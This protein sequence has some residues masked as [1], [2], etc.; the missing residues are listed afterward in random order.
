[1][2]ETEYKSIYG[3]LTTIPCVYEKALTNKKACC[4]LAEHFC[5]ADREGY[6]CQSMESSSLC[7]KFLEK[8]REK[9]VFSLKTQEVDGPLPHNMEIR[10]QAGGLQGL[11]HVLDG[12]RLDGV[13]E[14]SVHE[15][16]ERVLQRYQSVENFPY[17]EIVRAVSQFKG[18]QRR[19]RWMS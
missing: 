5:L 11:L 10:I 17:G 3:V 8:L 2:E 14:K 1:M 13:A 18:R 19:K 12:E 4:D 16:I 6:A 7:K 9:S 15:V